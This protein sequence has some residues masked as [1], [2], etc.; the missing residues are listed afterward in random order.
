MFNTVYSVLQH[1]QCFILIQD[2]VPPVLTFMLVPDKTDGSPL[3]TWNS[4]EV[5]NFECSYDQSSYVPC[6]RGLTGEWGR[7]DVRDGQH[8]FSVIGTDDVGNVGKPV[9]YTWTRGK[10]SLES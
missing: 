10:A 1:L 6:G 2:A 8:V 7:N 9:T 3:F 5:A 4:T